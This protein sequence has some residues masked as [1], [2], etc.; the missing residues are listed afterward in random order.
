MNKK[1][2]WIIVGII[3]VVLIIITSNL[4]KSNSSSIKIGFIG[5]LTGDAAAIGQNAKAA[6]ELATNEVNSAGGINGRPLQ[7]IYEDGQCNGTAASNAANKLINLDKVSM[8]FGGACSGET[9]AFTKTAQQNNIVVFSYCSSAPAL[10]QAGIFR[11]YPSDTFQGSYAADYLYNNL[12]K[13]NVAVLYVNTDWGIGIKDVL[14][15][16][17]NKLGGKIVDIEGF[18]Q[19]NPDFR[20]ILAKIKAANPDALLFLGY[21]QESITGLQQIG[22]IDLKV[23][24]FGG[25]TWDDPKIWSTVGSSGEGAMYVLPASNPSPAFKSAL[26][27]KVGSNEIDTCTPTAYDGL[28][29]IAQVLSKA[30]TDPVAI[31]NELHQIIYTGGV[32]SDKIQFDQNGDLVSANYAVKKVHNGTATVLT[33]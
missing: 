6:I 7:V 20:T 8:I 31:R 4:N 14:V 16:E 19:K 22:K 23:Q 25:D 11:D 13:K 17:F 28:K 2:I 10:S 3:V 30:G 1:I 18:D 26:A 29:I 32:S 12:G 33:Q 5:P 27:A 9:S 24:I 21:T 15:Q